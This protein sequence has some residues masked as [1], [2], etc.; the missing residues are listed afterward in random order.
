MI[1]N[2]PLKESYKMV[3]YLLRSATLYCVL[4]MTFA[5][6]L[7]EHNNYLQLD[8]TLSRCG[9]SVNAHLITQCSLR[10]KKL[11]TPHMFCSI[12]FNTTDTSS[13]NTELAC[14]RRNVFLIVKNKG[15]ATDLTYPIN[16]ACY[17]NSTMFFSYNGALVITN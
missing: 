17:S 15:T 3:T 10:P 7:F 4:Y 13:D 6:S 5:T 12:T 2:N 11:R 9:C 16:V 8:K 14:L 1:L